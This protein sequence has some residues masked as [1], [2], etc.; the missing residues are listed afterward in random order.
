MPRTQQK[1]WSGLRAR[2]SLGQHFLIDPNIV[3]KIIRIARPGEFQTVLEI[4]PGRGILTRALCQTGVT[5]VA[6]EID[7]DLVA[8]LRETLTDCPTLD[9]RHG[10]ALDFSFATL[11]KPAVV[12][13][14][15]PYYLSTPILFQLLEARD[16]IERMVLMVQSEVARRLTAEPGTKEYGGLSVLIQAYATVTRVFQVSPQCFRPRPDVDSTVISVDTRPVPLVA[17]RLQ[18]L[19]GRTVKAAFAHRRKTLANSLRDEGW[20]PQEIQEAL[21]KTGIP[22]SCRAERLGFQD[23][24]R[25]TQALETSQHAPAS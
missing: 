2:K 7:H 25:L 23:F 4:G 20:L 16:C 15:L 17:P 3:R 1:V 9:L 6:V 19:F 22:P 8:H 14:N 24:L 21:T 18:E 5:V 10:D 12:V 11:S 13:A